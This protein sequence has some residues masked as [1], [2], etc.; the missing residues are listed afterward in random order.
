M[1][2]TDRTRTVARITAV[3]LLLYATMVLVWGS[4]Y[5]FTAIALRGFAPMALVSARMA[6]A[7]LMLCGLVC[8]KRV[9]LPSRRVAMQLFALGICN[10]A[11]PFTLL[12][13]V[14]THLPSTLMSVLSATTPIFTFLIAGL[15]IRAEQV[16]VSRAVGIGLAF[17]GVACMHPPQ[18]G[19]GWIW[20]LAAAA[21]MLVFAIGNIAN[22]R[23]LAGVDP[24]LIAAG[25]IT[26]GALVSAPLAILEGHPIGRPGW[27]PVAALIELGLL[28]SA[29]CYLLY[30][31]SIQR[32]GSTVTSFSTFM[33][34]P[35]GLAL[36]VWVL[37]ETIT[38][39]QW[40]ALG[41]ILTGL[42][43]FT[44]GATLAPLLRRPS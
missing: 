39:Q 5:F 19:G 14:Q 26:T 37:G 6:I 43:I 10:V 21:A 8:I 31:R 17:V 34:Q 28:A 44:S 35:I 16:T 29:L 36:G 41:A 24:L 4:T 23:Y 18:G 22:N 33:Q 2:L 27:A 32:L 42:A 1:T 3:D 12:T 20:P 15:V 30:F 11:I 40:A 9:P 7:A 25:Q 13:I 38:A